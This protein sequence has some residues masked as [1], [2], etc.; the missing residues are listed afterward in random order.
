M[1]KYNCIT[2]RF[3]LDT[4]ENIPI[5]YISKYCG[6]FGRYYNEKTCDNVI[7]LNGKFIS[8]LEKIYKLCIVIKKF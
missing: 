5:N 6:E 2:N 4:D 7:L 1:V 3:S 8:L